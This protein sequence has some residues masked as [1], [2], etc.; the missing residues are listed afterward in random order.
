MFRYCKIRSKNTDA[1]C[2]NWKSDFIIKVIFSSSK[3]KYKRSMSSQSKTNCC[4]CFFAKF[5]VFENETF[6]CPLTTD[7]YTKKPNRGHDNQVVKHDDSMPMN[8]MKKDSPVFTNGQIS[9][10]PGNAHINQ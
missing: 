1:D 5:K 2:L 4:L 3:K 8:G 9:D 6:F 7:P 10:G